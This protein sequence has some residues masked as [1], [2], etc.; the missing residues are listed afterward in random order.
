MR[1]GWLSEKISRY[2]AG[3]LLPNSSKPIS[4][5]RML[6]MGPFSPAA[7][8]GMAAALNSR[9]Q[10]RRISATSASLLAK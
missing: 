7:A 1:S 6:A 2:F 8:E 10:A 4:A 9:M 5:A 3:W